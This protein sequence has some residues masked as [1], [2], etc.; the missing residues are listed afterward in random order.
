M[1]GNTIVFERLFRIYQF[2]FPI[3][4]HSNLTVRNAVAK[5]NERRIISNSNKLVILLTMSTFLACTF[6]IFREMGSSNELPYWENNLMC[7]MIICRFSTGF[8]SLFQSSFHYKHLPLVWKQ[9]R[10][11]N[12]LSM[13][14]LGHKICF[15]KFFWDFSI[16]LIFGFIIFITYLTLRLM[17]MS[18]GL[19]SVS[20]YAIVTLH[21]V[22]LYTSVHVLFILNLFRYFTKLLIKFIGMAYRIKVHHMQFA[23]TDNSVFDNLRYFKEFHYKLYEVGYAINHFFGIILMALSC[24]TFIDIAFTAYYL[25]LYFVRKEADLLLISKYVP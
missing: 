2:V 17:Y 6:A 7:F 14:K 24:Q 25:F 12:K 18:T 15:R 19:S 3:F 16:D 10:E 5:P 20:Q 23:Q 4:C 1:C 9:Y 11:I 21:C 8:S 22:S 13:E